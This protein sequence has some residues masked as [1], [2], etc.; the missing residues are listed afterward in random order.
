M[1]DLI[2]QQIERLR[3]QG[4]TYVDTRWYP[5]EETNS[6]LMWNGNLKETTSSRESGVG[7][8]V[9][10]KGA[11]GFS[12]SS[13]L[14]NFSALF[15]KAFDNAR[16]A[17]ERVTFP[18]R[19]A[20]KEAVE[21]KFESPS[22]INPFEVPLTEKVAFLRE[23]DKLLDQPGIT[24]RMSSLD[25]RRKQIIFVDSEGSQ[26]EKVITDVFTSLE[27]N[28][29]DNEGG[30]HER[31]FSPPRRGDTRGWETIDLQYFGENAE[32]IVRELNAT[33]QA[34]QCPVDDR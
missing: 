18:V 1:I 9:L 31:K 29:L 7:V 11:W 19:L 5:Y 8:R 10:Y 4:A 17:A 12:A 23:M 32:R 20:E 25:F 6:L 26:I 34:E 16:V 22:R 3:A 24:Q 27:V 28:G 15:D 21:A 33:L 2:K 14:G 13:D 30:M